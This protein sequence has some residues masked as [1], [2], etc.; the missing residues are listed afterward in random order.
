MLNNCALSV[1][2]TSKTQLVKLFF[3]KPVKKSKP[4]KKNN[5]NKIK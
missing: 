1:D 3:D 4:K 2:K 5:N